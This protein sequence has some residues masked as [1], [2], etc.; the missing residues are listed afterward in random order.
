[1]LIILLYGGGSMGGFLTSKVLET[2]GS[3]AG[4]IIM[5]LITAPVT[6]WRFYDYVYRTIHEDSRP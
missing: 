6:D 2:Q 4:P 1:M 5:V 3:D